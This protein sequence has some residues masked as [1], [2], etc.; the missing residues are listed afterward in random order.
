V[1][2]LSGVAG[3]EIGGPVTTAG[4]MAATAKEGWFASTQSHRA[5]SAVHRLQREVHG[6]GRVDDGVDTLDR[7][8]EGARGHNVLNFEVLVLRPIAA[9]RPGE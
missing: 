3:Q 5:R 6:R 9:K 1:F 4:L 7:L 8:V 2:S